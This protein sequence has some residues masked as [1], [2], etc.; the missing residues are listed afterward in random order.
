MAQKQEQNEGEQINI[1]VKKI[2]LPHFCMQVGAWHTVNTC[3][4]TVAVIVQKAFFY[5]KRR[6]IC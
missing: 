4:I 6:K 1:T 5:R 2:I 3:E